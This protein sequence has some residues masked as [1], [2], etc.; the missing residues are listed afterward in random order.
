MRQGLIAHKRGIALIEKDEG[1]E[2]GLQPTPFGGE[3]ASTLAVNGSGV[4]LAGNRQGILRSRDGGKRWAAA[5]MGLDIRHVRW[6][7]SHPDD[8]TIFYAG[9]EPAGIFV[10]RNGGAI[11]NNCREVGA[12]RDRY[13][14]MLPYSPE[15]GCVRGFAFHGMRGYAAVEVGAALV[16]ENG[17]VRWGLSGGSDGQPD[18]SSPYDGR[19]QADVHSIEVHVSDKNLVFAITGG[20]LY[21]SADGGERW[22]RL[23]PCYSRAGWIDPEDAN[24]IIFGAADSVGSGGRIEQSRDGGKTWAQVSAEKWADTMPERMAQVGSS[25]FCVLDDSRILVS[26]APYTEWAYVFPEIR[27]NMI[28]AYP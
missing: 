20:G 1:G 9:T 5:N 19:V 16:S 23:Y 12:M 4:V 22:K 25:L 24:H 27:A 21:R 3:A 11:W 6:L 26:E 8:D 17:G 18:F 28:V 10:S 2:W 15:A 7:A 14:W 13:G